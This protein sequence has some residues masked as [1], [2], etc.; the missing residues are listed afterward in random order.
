MSL[1]H[2]GYSEVTNYAYHGKLLVHM[3]VRDDIL[4]FFYDNEHNP[5]YTIFKGEFY[6]Y[7]HNLQGD[8]VGILDNSGALVVE[9]KYG[10]W[11]N[12]LATTG[13]LAATLGKRNP[14]RY[15]G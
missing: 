13:S 14:F 7:I 9:Y 8:I 5:S 10:A 15:R 4:H 2:N 6:R 11:G 1:H 3:N 12:P